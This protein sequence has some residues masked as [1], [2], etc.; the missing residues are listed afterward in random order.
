MLT[1]CAPRSERDKRVMSTRLLI[2]RVL[3]GG[4]VVGKNAPEFGN[5]R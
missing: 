3:G 4:R 1:M 5:V 2:P